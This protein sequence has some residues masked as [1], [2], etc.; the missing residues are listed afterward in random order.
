MV[1]DAFPGASP[2]AITLGAF[3][4]GGPLT[5]TDIMHGLKT[6]LDLVGCPD[7]CR[8]YRA[9]NNGSGCFSWGFTPGCHIRGFQ[10]RRST[11][12]DGHHAWIEDEI[13]FGRLS[14]RVSPLQGEE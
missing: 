11:N 7:V 1:R 10:P 2:Q 5:R 13:G 12:Q 4:P 3:S 14:R 6:K 8:P 9:K